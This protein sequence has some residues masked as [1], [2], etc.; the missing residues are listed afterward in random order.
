MPATDHQHGDRPCQ[1]DRRQDEGHTEG[2]PLVELVGREA[3][4][5]ADGDRPGDDEDQAVRIASTLH[6]NPLCR[7]ASASYVRSADPAASV[8]SVRVSTRTALR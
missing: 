6:R 8:L 2:G 1:R 7:E 3:C 4:V 5:D